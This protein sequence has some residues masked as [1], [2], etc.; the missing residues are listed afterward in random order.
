V[1]NFDPAHT[2]NYVMGTWGA[3]RRGIYVAFIADVS[4]CAKR[5]DHF[6]PAWRSSPVRKEKPSMKRVQWAIVGS[7]V[8]GLFAIPAFADQQQPQQPP[9]Q[10]PQQQPLQQGEQ[11]IQGKAEMTEIGLSQ[12]PPLVRAAIENWA[13]GSEV[14]KVQEARQGNKIQ[15]VAEIEREGKNLRVLVNQQGQVLRAGEDI[16]VEKKLF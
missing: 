3:S 12:T 11:P 9:Q 1:N 5:L 2:A 13:K 6:R 7:L 10:Q 8:T 16:G 15:Y 4:I 14:K